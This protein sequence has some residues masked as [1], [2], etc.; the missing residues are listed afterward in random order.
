[1]RST[2]WN[3]AVVAVMPTV[4]VATTTPE[5]SACRRSDRAAYRQ[6]GAER[7]EPID[8]RPSPMRAQVQALDLR[9]DASVVAEPAPRLALGLGERHPARHQLVDPSLNVEVELGVHVAAHS[10]ERERQSKN[11]S[12]HGCVPPAAAPAPAPAFAAM[13]IATASE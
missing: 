8:H 13:S 6:I 3:I 10:A 12:C 4:S 5:N 1:M 9:L 2:A 7:L 11:A